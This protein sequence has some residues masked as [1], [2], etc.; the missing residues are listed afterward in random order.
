MVPQKYK[1]LQK[2]WRYCEVIWSAVHYGLGSIAAGL[3][4]VASSPE[5]K[6]LAGVESDGSTIIIAS[7]VVASILTFLS[8]ASRR[9][10][11]TEACNLLRVTR[12]RYEIEEG[13]PERSLIDAIEKGQEIIAKR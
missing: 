3:A 11:Y 12:L 8:P 2:E 4:F 9:K 5:L 6:A 13:I 1:K 7:G 10:A